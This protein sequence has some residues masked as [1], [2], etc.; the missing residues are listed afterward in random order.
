MTK[1]CLSKSAIKVCQIQVCRLCRILLTLPFT[2]LTAI[3]HEAISY[4]VPDETVTVTFKESLP[5]GE[6]VLNLKFS[7]IIQS[8]LRGFY[9]AK[10]GE[11][12]AMTQMA[13][14]D[15][16]RAF[17]CFDEPAL[18]ASFDITLIVP[19]DP[20][21]KALSNMDVLEEKVVNGFREVRFSRTPI[22]SSYLVAY[23][24]GQ[25]DRIESKTTDGVK[26]GIYT[27]VGK[28]EQGRFALDVA[29]KSLDF[30]REYF[31]IPYPLN[32]C[33]LIAYPDL[34]YG[35]MEVRTDSF[36]LKNFHLSLIFVLELGSSI[37]PPKP[38]S[39]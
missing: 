6:A 17:P 12:T 13:P 24:I 4:S 7:G 8:S 25:F 10:S 18:K 37:L 9:K 15:A 39:R 27:P 31:G 19:T 32:K 5:V 38:P 33:D 1:R 2:I 22:M 35:A 3:S 20:K 34:S 21:I 26:V 28:A 11:A 16:R 29:V 23:A 36:L 14:T 30:Y